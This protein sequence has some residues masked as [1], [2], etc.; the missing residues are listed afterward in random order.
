VAF[1]LLVYKLNNRR[2]LSCASWVASETAF[3]VYAYV[4]FIHLLLT[5]PAV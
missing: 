2:C 1:P 5:R 3:Y 4:Q